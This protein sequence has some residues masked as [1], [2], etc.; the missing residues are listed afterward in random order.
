MPTE[1]NDKLLKRVVTMIAISNIP[2]LIFAYWYLPQSVGWF[3]GSLGSALRIIWLA[4]DVQKSLIHV[5][6]KAK[7]AAAKGFYLRFLGLLV[8]SVAVVYF[9]KPDIIMFGFGLLTAQICI[10]IDAVIQR[11]KPKD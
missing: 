4:R 11:F 7:I 3:F 2:F 10:Y 1:S 5:E 9:L 6:Q 8:Y